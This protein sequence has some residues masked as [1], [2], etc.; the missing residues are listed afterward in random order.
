MSHK[1]RRTEQIHVP[2]R[3]D[4]KVRDAIRQRGICRRAM[5]LPLSGIRHVR[6]LY[7][8]GEIYGHSCY[9]M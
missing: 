3:H 8:N 2:I 1:I 7:R 6:V 9:E 4:S 5:S